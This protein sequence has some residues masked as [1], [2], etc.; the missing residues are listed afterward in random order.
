MSLPNFLRRRVPN[1]D[2][3]NF[4]FR[5]TIKRRV[6]APLG[7]MH[8]RLLSIA[9]SLI[10]LAG[11]GAAARDAGIVAVGGDTGSAARL[12]AVFGT[13]TSVHRTVERNRLVGG[14]PNSYHLAGRAIDIARRPG[15]TH[16]QI[17]TALRRAG[18]NLVESLDEGDHSHFAFAP[19][20]ASAHAYAAALA[21]GG[22]GKALD[23]KSKV[24]HPVL[25]DNH[26]T[27]LIDLPAAGAS[28]GTSTAR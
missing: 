14:V 26:G 20:S 5:D 13:V 28:A 18:Y 17:A 4:R 6:N 2:R 3:R 12:A 11:S 7:V 19:A 9:M 8:L 23:T 1:C 22:P 15:V 24:E 27:L 16:D 25:A 21:P 10:L